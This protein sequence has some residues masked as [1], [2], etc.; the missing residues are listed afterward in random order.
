VTDAGGWALNETAAENS[1]RRDRRGPPR[2]RGALA[3]SEDALCKRGRAP[4]SLDPLRAGGERGGRPPDRLGDEVGAVREDLPNLFHHVLDADAAELIW[5]LAKAHREVRGALHAH[6]RIRPSAAKRKQA[7]FVLPSTVAPIEF[8][9]SVNHPGG[10]IPIIS[11]CGRWKA[12]GV[13]SV[14]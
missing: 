10:V 12:L 6:V 13:T 14:T 3:C 1:A 11:V 8:P 4:C 7:T 9:S 2:D 5:H